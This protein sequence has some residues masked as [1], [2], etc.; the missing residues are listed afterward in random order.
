MHITPT[1]RPLPRDA[2]SILHQTLHCLITIVVGNVHH[3]KSSIAAPSPLHSLQPP[4][5]RVGSDTSL[6]VIGQKKSWKNGEN[7]KT[8]GYRHGYIFVSRKPFW[9][10]PSFLN[11]SQCW[12]VAPVLNSDVR[13]ADLWR[14]LPSHLEASGRNHGKRLLQCRPWVPDW[15][16]GRPGAAQVGPF[17]ILGA[18]RIRAGV[19]YAGTRG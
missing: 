12:Y 14:P 18:L 8:S 3:S 11:T 16:L 6:R 10:F 7:L 9:R 13:S 2:H 5:N 15:P 4:V 17:H 1:P 19:L